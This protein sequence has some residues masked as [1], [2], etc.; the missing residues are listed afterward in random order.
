MTGETN[1]ARSA[2]SIRGARPRCDTAAGAVEAFRNAQVEIEPPPHARL[3]EKHAPFWNEIMQTR[4]AREW[5]A[6]DLQVAAQ[7]A[8]GFA[9]MAELEEVVDRDG[10]FPARGPDGMPIPHAAL[11]LQAELGAKCLALM[12]SLQINARAVPGGRAEHN[13]GRRGAERDARS[14]QFDDDDP[15]L[16]MMPGTPQWRRAQGIAE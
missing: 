13:L 3:G 7:L 15:I 4:S 11:R 16:A 2:R 5:T 10:T 14:A 9:R 12:R 1:E 6:V 8:R